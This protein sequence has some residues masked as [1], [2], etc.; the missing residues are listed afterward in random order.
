MPA[1]VNKTKILKFVD[2]KDPIKGGF[3]N[4]AELMHDVVKQMVNGGGFVVK[5]CSVRDTVLNTIPWGAF[6]VA[7]VWSPPTVYPPVGSPPSGTYQETDGGKDIFNAITSGPHATITLE[8]GGPGVIPS[9][10]SIP[11]SL[12]T[13]VDYLNPTTGPWSIPNYT[14]TCS[15]YIVPN[16]ADGGATG[17]LTALPDLVFGKFTV[18]MKITGP[19]VLPGTEIIALGSALGGADGTYIVNKSQ[20]VPLLTF[21]ISGA[22]TSFNGAISGT[23]LTAVTPV[24]GTITHNLIISGSIVTSTGTKSIFANTRI[25]T[26]LSDI[27]STPQATTTAT[28]ALGATS[29]TVASATGI[30]AGQLLEGEGIPQG[31]FVV[32]TYTSGTTID[33]VDYQGTAVP[34]VKVMAATA[35]N[36]YTPGGPGTYLV[37]RY[38]VIP[39]GLEPSVLEGESP[40]VRTV[41]NETWRVR[42]ELHNNESVSAYVGTPLQLPG[43]SDPATKVPEPWGIPG[44][45]SKIVDPR[46][47]IVDTA[48]AIGARQY[49]PTCYTVKGISVGKT[50][51]GASITITS[52]TADGE[53]TLTKTKTF[54]LGSTITLTDKLVAGGGFA[55]GDQYYVLESVSPAANKVKITDTYANAVSNTPALFPAGAITKGTAAVDATPGEGI[56]YKAGDI[57]YIKDPMLSDSEGYSGTVFIKIDSVNSTGGVLAM[58][59]LDGGAL[60]KKSVLTSAEKTRAPADPKLKSIQVTGNYYNLYSGQYYSGPV[61]AT[62]TTTTTAAPGT[63]P[64]S[65]SGLWVSLVIANAVTTTPDQGPGAGGH[66]SEIDSYQGFFSRGLRVGANGAS[67]PL[68]YYLSIANSGFFLGIYESDWATSAG[69]TG[70]VTKFTA[71]TVGTKLYAQDVLGTITPGMTL[72]GDV[73]I[74]GGLRI[75]DYN[76]PNVLPSPLTDPPAGDGDSGTY[77]LSMTPFKPIGSW[78][79]SNGKVEGETPSGKKVRNPPIRLSGYS[80]DARFNWML[81]QRPVNRTTGVILDNYES[82]SSKHPVFCLYSVGGRTAH[83]TVREKDIVHPQSGPADHT[84]NAFYTDFIQYGTPGEYDNYPYRI[85]SGINSEDSHSLYNNQN[86][87]AL[88]EEKTYLITFPNNLTSARFRYTEEIDIIGYTSSDLLMSGQQIDFKTYNESQSRVYIALPPSGRYNTGVRFCVLKQTNNT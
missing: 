66:V 8:A 86:Q 18:G 34:I 62:T 88:T 48:G 87:I 10:G 13:W 28:G 73:R 29:I 43:W 76:D 46:G 58:T 75:L 39:D 31:T 19:G 53:C 42:F 67:Y 60:V 70:T 16:P 59:V 74:P 9:G 41:L 33:L 51:A 78:N 3:L 64:S 30:V 84:A 77:E 82:K 20:V 22:S 26:Q 6:D 36:F 21:P 61:S 79:P 71:A 85:P 68:K 11:P 15:G 52:I 12:A 65:G 23:I 35:V 63:I 25:I 44:S 50:A 69:G 47:V 7:N 2:G 49:V 56:G 14:A 38:Q 24:T 37:S 1:N 45:V 54:T 80:G 81:V 40:D 17:V 72:Q 4:V 5:H 83:F 27:G 57:V 32:A 55:Y